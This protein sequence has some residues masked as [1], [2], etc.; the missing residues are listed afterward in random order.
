MKN[1]WMGTCIHLLHEFFFLFA[2]SFC[3]GFL[4]SVLSNSFAFAVRLWF[5]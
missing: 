5:D 3:F 4:A 2:F 1:V